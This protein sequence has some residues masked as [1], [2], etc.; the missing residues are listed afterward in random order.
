LSPGKRAIDCQIS[1]VR[2]MAA[3]QTAAADSLNPCIAQLDKLDSISGQNIC[4]LR[5]NNDMKNGG[6]S[7]IC[8]LRIT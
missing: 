4:N 7:S 6:H 3:Q 1:H 2:L 5:G 8:Q